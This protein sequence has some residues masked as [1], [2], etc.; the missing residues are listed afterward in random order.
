MKLLRPGAKARDKITGFSGVITALN[1]ELVGTNQLHCQFRIESA[2][3]DGK[4]ADNQWFDVS[5]V[6]PDP[7]AQ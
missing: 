5:R 4:P 2:S 3:L 6:E 1:Q 7:F